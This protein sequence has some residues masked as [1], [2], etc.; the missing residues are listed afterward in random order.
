MTLSNNQ[1]AFFSLVKAGLWEQDAQLAQYDE[2]DYSEVMRLAEE[3]SVVGLVV[4]GLEHVIDV[5]V[6]KE[7]VLHFVGRTLQL[8]QRNIAMNA[9][10]ATLIDNLRSNGI[11]AVLVKGQGVAQC[12]ERPL[13]RASGD[14]DLLLDT[15]NYERAKQ[16]LLPLAEN[17]EDEFKSFK[18]IGMTLPG[19]FVVELHGTLHS[20]LSNRV[21][22]VID[23]VQKD[24]FFG[25]SVR[26]WQDGD[27]LIVLPAP[28]NDI[29]FVFTHILHHFFLEGVGLRQICDWCRLLWTFRK[30]IHVNQVE[31]WLREAGLMNE[32]MSFAAMA[33]EWLG[34]PVEAMPFYDSQYRDKGEKILEFVLETGNFG[35]NRRIV[36]SGSL[37][38]DKTNSLWRKVKDFAHHA[39]VFPMNSVR[40]FPHF[41]I[42]GLK[43][44]TSK[45]LCGTHT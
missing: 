16:L 24:V 4:A 35:H 11:N 38:G 19:G 37:V 31:H 20:R 25:G 42:N 2:I 33:V 28:D 30:E 10:V 40:F 5:R 15:D 1:Q 22:K 45:I 39:R 26:A 12:F 23:N 3:Q 17:V 44:A 13:W 27:S 41:A 36:S 8:E 18:H 34:M 43:E 14:V 9:Y 32:W 6:P 7:D 29:F 21:D